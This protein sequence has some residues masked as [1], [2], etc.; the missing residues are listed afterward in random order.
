MEETTTAPNQQT[1]GP[2]MVSG[3]ALSDYQQTDVYKLFSPTM[4]FPHVNLGPNPNFDEYKSIIG[5][6]TF[7]PINNPPSGNYVV[8]GVTYT[9]APVPTITSISIYFSVGMNNIL[10]AKSASNILS[11]SFYNVLVAAGSLGIGMGD[12]SPNSKIAIMT[13]VFG[14]S[15]GTSSI[16]T[17]LFD[18]AAAAQKGGSRAA[19]KTSNFESKLHKYTRDIMSFVQKHAPMFKSKVGRRST[20]KS[21]KSRR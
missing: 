3:L 15:D 14:F 8:G 20:R 19:K 1:A 11:L 10:I 9:Y 18:Q 7:N 17:G 21:H 4:N 13:Y 16:V 12:A 5:T 2:S 6:I